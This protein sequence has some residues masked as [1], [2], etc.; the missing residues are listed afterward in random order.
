MDT[1]I[2]ASIL[3]ANF[4]KLSDEISSVLDMNVVSKLIDNKYIICNKNILSAT[5]DGRL[6]L[7]SVIAKIIK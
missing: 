4:A 5:F 1:I 3:S 2:A 6:R 7:N